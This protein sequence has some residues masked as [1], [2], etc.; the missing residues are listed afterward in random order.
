MFL[1]FT[2]THSLLTHIC[3]WVSAGKDPG[4]DYLL[5]ISPDVSREIWVCVT[6]CIIKSVSKIIRYVGYGVRMLQ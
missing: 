5:I 6:G 4:F 3:R 1:K 2:T